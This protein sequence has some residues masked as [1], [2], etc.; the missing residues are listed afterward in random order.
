MAKNKSI[1]Q[2]IF[3]IELL[4]WHYKF[5]AMRIFVLSLI[6]LCSITS[7]SQA[8][9]KGKITGKV[10]DSES[11]VPI[12]MAIVSIFREGE[13]KAFNGLSTD[14][15]GAFTID[16]LPTGAYK[17]T[18]DFISYK[19]IVLNAVKVN[20]NNTVNLG[21][22]S[23][24]PSSNQLDEVKIVSKTATVQNKI[25]K[26]VYNTANDLTSQGGVATDVLKNVPMVS[27][28]IDGNVELQGNPNIRFLIN[29]KPSSIFGASVSDALQAIPASQIKS[30]E[31]ITSPGARYDAAG[32][33][34]IINIILKESKVQGINSSINLSAGT[35]LENGSF[36]LNARK[37]NFGMGVYFSGNKQLNTKTKSSSDR[38]SYNATRDSIN[39]LYQNG[40]S[41]FTRSGYQTGINFNWSIT[42]KDELTGTLGYN[43]FENNASGMTMQDQTSSL[44]NGTILS[45]L[46]SER[47]STSNFR[48][49][50]TD[51][52][53][54]Y[55]KTF[56]REDQELNVLVTSS[57]GKSVNN[58]GQQTAYEN[59]VNPVSGLRSYNPGQDHQ[60]EMSLDFVRPIAK[61]YTFE[62]GSK[63][64]LENIDSNVVTDTLAT[65]GSYLNNQGQT[66]GFKY[67]R[68]IYAA[69][70]S[71]SFS[72][73]NSFLVGKAGL[74]YERT[75]TT[76]DFVGVSIP[77]YNT[78]APSFTMQHKFGEN[79]SIKFAYSYR[80]ERPD[81]EELNPF[82][83]ISDPHN[84]STGNPFLKPEIG[85]RFELGYSKTFTNGANVYF[86]GYY[87]YNTDDIQSFTTFHSVLD[88]NGTNYTDVTL[89]QRYNIGSQT[90]IGASIFGSLAVADKL[91]IRS[92][93]EFGER[94]N[95]TPGYKTVSGFA[96]RANLNL[97]YQFSPT[98][99]G[100]IF[101]NFRSSQKNLQGNRPS[102]FFYNMAVRKQFLHKT[103]SVGITMANPF[104]KYLSQRST[105]YGESFHQVN[106]K[107]IPVQSFGISFN[108][109]FGK[110]EF[111]K[112]ESDNHGEPQEPT[113]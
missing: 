73:F 15:N 109:K 18:I 50:A 25:D 27:V 89:T 70:F 32:T 103:A 43:H 49:N 95:S 96:Y 108:Y 68:N 80:I 53:I 21:N 58:A 31:V 16:N 83:N 82:F 51:W 97:S 37:G 60:V 87:R 69:Y 48:N 62:M 74:R 92:T 54:G 17:I 9:G 75:N 8:T 22:V 47:N 85:N 66:Y 6:L 26:M 2:D 61:G 40:V 57:Y 35:R 67:K 13:T 71:S 10:I 94:S 19:E 107:D 33:G 29:G 3:K 45:E 104:N 23:L 4:F 38:I 14:Q 77:D 84:I 44:S 99:M 113:I 5:F 90:N 101:G 86:S 28:D 76:A 79:Q 52:S 41:P 39:R 112:G 20:G 36:N 1:I 110:L 93:I 81:Y 111:K 11:K 105:S 64:S 7:F 30:I 65:D 88:V 59:D 102:S 98:M 100:E 78:F 55:K 106:V 46:I 63:V 91:N 42:P 56:E 12:E 72:L 24:A 34:G